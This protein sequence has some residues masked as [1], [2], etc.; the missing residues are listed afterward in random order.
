MALY[1][2][3]M[4]VAL[5]VKGDFLLGVDLSA[6][7]FGG[8]DQATH[9]VT[10]RLPAPRVTSARVDHERTR[11]V[12]VSET[13]IWTIVPGDAGLRA[14]IIDQAFREAQRTV[15]GVAADPKWIDQSRQQAQRVLATFFRATGWGVT[16]KWE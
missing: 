3:G 5:I 7:R 10:L 16:V 1:L 15:A 4:R 14:R 12:A 11:V 2:G 9:T 8:M 6:A 13:G